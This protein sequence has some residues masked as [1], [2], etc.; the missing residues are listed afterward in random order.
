MQQADL[1][2]HRKV[3]RLVHGEELGLQGKQQEVHNEAAQVPDGCQARKEEAP[4]P[5]LQEED[6]LW[7]PASKSSRVAVLCRHTFTGHNPVSNGP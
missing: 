1:H 2:G 5:Q 6:S 3:E 7:Q 4:T